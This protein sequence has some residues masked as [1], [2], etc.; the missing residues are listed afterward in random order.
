M[1]NIHLPYARHARDPKTGQ[2]DPTTVV[3]PV[4]GEPIKLTEAKD[5]ESFSMTAYADHY[6]AKH[7]DDEN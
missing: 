7:A 6:E 3:C 4:C 1:S 5:F 2:I